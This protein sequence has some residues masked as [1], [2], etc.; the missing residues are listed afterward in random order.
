MRLCSD[1]F[2]FN[3]LKISTVDLLNSLGAYQLENHGAQ[4][5]KSIDGDYYT[6]LGF[7]L[8]PCLAFLREIKFIQS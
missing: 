2:A 5:F 3:Y 7:L 4:L 6:I 8:L 1:E